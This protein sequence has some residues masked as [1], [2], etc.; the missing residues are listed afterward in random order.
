VGAAGL[1]PEYAEWLDRVTAT[2]EAV[3][4]TCRVR[5]GDAAAGRV[6]ALRV[7]TGLVARP[8][9]FRHWGL[10]FSGRIAKLAEDAIA[11]VLA[12]RAGSGGD[13]GAFR[14]ALAEV[15]TETQMTFV[16]T[17]VEG[18]ADEQ[19]AGRCGCDDATA[20]RR[21][22]STLE[23]MRGLAAEHAGSGER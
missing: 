14:L 4:Y 5:L 16:L 1:V 8:A 15:S 9:V 20:R 13:W 19:V 21:R 10:P 6:V 3:S 22:A 11:D 12:G 17:C 2:Y 18:L 7:A 23:L